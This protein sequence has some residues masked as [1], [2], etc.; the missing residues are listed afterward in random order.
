[1]DAARQSLPAATF[2]KLDGQRL[3]V[4][5]FRGQT[6]SGVEQSGGART[7]GFERGFRGPGFDQGLDLPLQQQVP[8]V[9]IAD[10]ADLPVER[11][12]GFEGG[13]GGVGASK[14]FQQVAALDLDPGRQP[15][16]A[17]KDRGHGFEVGGQGFELKAG[18]G[19]AWRRGRA[20]S[21]PRRA[22]GWLGCKASTS[23]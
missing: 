18:F 20:V 15:G 14:L 9:G 3:L 13:T 17:T 16:V 1:M 10:R 4:Q 7:V 19:G 12:R 2:E 23:R 5:P 8:G 21:S 22:P 6:A 11:Q